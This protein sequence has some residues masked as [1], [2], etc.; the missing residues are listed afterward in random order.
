[1][2]PVDLSFIDE[3]NTVIGGGV[4]V[5]SY[6]FGTYW[7]L[8]LAF[9]LLN[10]IDWITGIIKA[11]VFKVESSAAGIKGVMKKL[12]YW[13]MIA[14]AFL[15]TVVFNE[16]GK[17]I[18][19][20]ISQF[21]PLIGY[22]VLAML[23]VNEIRSIL[24]NLYQ[25]GVDV[26]PILLKGLAV[27]EKVALDAQSKIFDG[28]LEIRSNTENPFHVKIDTPTEELEHKDSVTLMIQTVSDDDIS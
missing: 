6:V 9:I 1:M 3:V 22:M 14:V 7:L 13:I 16:L 18:G 12:A 11:K 27:F 15:M 23:I 5:L 17:I 21:S 25:C 2:E 24:E 10:I 28:K 26:P 19:A 4:V 20:D 8:F